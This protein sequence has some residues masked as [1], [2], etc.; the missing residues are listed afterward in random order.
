[1]DYRA[2]RRLHERWLTYPAYPLQPDLSQDEYR[3]RVARAREEMASQ[4]LDALVI[5]S[6]TIGQWFTGRP[7]PHEWHDYCQARSTW[8]VL[9]HEDDCLFMPPTTGGEHFST[10]RRSTWVTTI[11]GIV[12]C[13]VWPRVELWALEQIPELFADLGIDR[14][15]LGF[16]LGDC[17]T[18]GISFNDF[19]RL[20]ELLPHAECVDASP[21]LRRL[22][23]I[24]TP[25][26]IARIRRACEAA[27]WIHNQVPHVLRPGMTERAFVTELARRFAAHFSEEYAYQ[28]EAGWDVRNP[29]TGDSNPYHAVAT[30]RVFKL[31]DLV[32]RGTSGVSYRGYDGDVDRLW[33]I[34]T[35]PQAVIDRYR[36][37]WE[38]SRAMAEQIRPG[39][40]C[41]DVY[42][43]CAAVERRYG[44][45][46][47]ETGRVGH[48]IRN[49]GG[50]SVFP[51]NH[52]VLEPNMVLSVEPMFSTEY[53]WITVE[54]QFLVTAGG[55]E[56]LHEAAPEQLPVIS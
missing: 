26:E 30:D 13:A 3:C 35:P 31:G 43:A 32:A 1:M 54:E 41:S 4:A 42:Q 18:L 27:V 6:G 53:G 56:M 12:E 16:E 14:G 23:S 8:Y 39:N 25:E 38:C 20:R 2:L 37:A 52:T 51:S 55:A 44:L 40:R 28:A 22:M 29:L 48:G 47:R 11:S 49:T 34:G 17:M 46:R 15:R 9:T 19:L 7:E 21:V 50:L 5:T 45:P 36:I 33:Y 24:H 10:T